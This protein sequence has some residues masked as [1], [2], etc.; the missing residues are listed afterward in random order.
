MVTNNLVDAPLPAPRDVPPRPWVILLVAAILLLGWLTASGCMALVARDADAE[1][2]QAEQKMHTAIAG[3]AQQMVLTPAERELA[4]FARFQNELAVARGL[5]QPDRSMTAWH[6]LSATGAAA[7]PG[8]QAAAT[9]AHA[10]AP[11]WDVA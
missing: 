11:P 1:R 4:E 10:A 2:E 9:A 7:T 5:A 3:V 8:H 6:Q